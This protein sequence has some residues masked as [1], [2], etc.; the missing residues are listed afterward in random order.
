MRSTVTLATYFETLYPN[1][2]LNVRLCQDLSY[3]DALVAKRLSTLTKLERALAIY[4][5][6]Q[7]KSTVRVG[8]MLEE[9]DAI[10]CYTKLLDDLNIAVQKEQLTAENLAKYL[11]KMAR[12]TSI[13]VIESFLEVTEIGAVSKMLRRK[14]S[15]LEPMNLIQDTNLTKDETKCNSDFVAEKRFR[16]KMDF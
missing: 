5:K 16:K 6:S 2:I 4:K 9:V 3:L 15:R 1:A 13:N 11:D 8:D 14:G 7:V 12:A 10:K